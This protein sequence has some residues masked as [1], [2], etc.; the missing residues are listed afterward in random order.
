MGPPDGLETTRS[1]TLEQLQNFP[2]IL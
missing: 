2:S 1:M